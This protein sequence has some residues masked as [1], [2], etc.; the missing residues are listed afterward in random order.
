MR[1]LA[2]ILLA[3]FFIFHFTVSGQNTRISAK[4]LW[5][6]KSPL[7]GVTVQVKNSKISTATLED[8][9]FTI[10]A[11]SAGK[12]SLIFSSIG[13]KTQEFTVSPGSPVELILT[14]EAKGL[15]DV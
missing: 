7:G 8:G 11:P 1:N 6:Q 9:S 4:V 2:L 14:E 10:N 15:T 13:F 5:S 12:T 3:V